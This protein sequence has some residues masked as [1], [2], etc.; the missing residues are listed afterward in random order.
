VFLVLDHNF[1]VMVQQMVVNNVMMETPILMMDVAMFVCFRLA[2]IESS[3]KLAK[4]VIMEQGTDRYVHQIMDLPV[5][6]V[7]TT[8]KFKH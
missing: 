3:I 5:A 6:F 4:A 1:V 2:E 8:V 7:Q